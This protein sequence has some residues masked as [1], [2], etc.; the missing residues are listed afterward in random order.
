MFLDVAY[1]IR[2]EMRQ[3]GYLKPDVVGVFFVP[4]AD[5]NTQ[6]SPRAPAILTP[7]LTELN[8]FQSKRS[9]YQTAFDKSESAD[10]RQ[11]PAVLAGY[12][13]QLPR[14][15]DPGAVAARRWQ[16]RLA[17]CSTRCSHGPGVPAA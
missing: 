10:Y 3:V 4:P 14:G 9:R 2:H 7:A 12:L 16:P 17:R 13:L 1:L 6:R 11:R 15:A 8:Q 5:A